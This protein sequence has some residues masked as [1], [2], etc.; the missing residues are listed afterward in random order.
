[1]AIY[2]EAN[3]RYERTT[4]STGK[5]QKVNEPYLVDAQSMS[6]AEARVTKEVSPFI[7]GE[8]AVSATKQSNI[9]EVF[10]GNGDW[11]Y[12][13]KVNF[14]TVDEKTGAE[15]KVPYYYLVQAPDLKS[16]YDSF[17]EKMRNTVDD[18]EVHSIIETKIMDV[19]DA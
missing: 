15:K 16:A 19:F 17:V 14:I 13:V 9:T 18:Y 10:R 5:T 7:C 1:M 3:V 11:W 4:D 2:I 8:F 12:K 6:E